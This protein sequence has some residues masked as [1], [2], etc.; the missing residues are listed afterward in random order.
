LLGPGLQ[1]NRELCLPEHL[2]R[3]FCTQASWIVAAGALVSPRSGKAQSLYSAKTRSLLQSDRFQ[4]DSRDEML[5]RH[6][7]FSNWL[8]AFRHCSRTINRVLFDLV[9]LLRLAAKSRSAPVAGE[10]TRLK[11]EKSNK[12]LLITEGKRRRKKTLKSRTPP[13]SNA[14]KVGDAAPETS[15][16]PERPNP[17]TLTEVSKAG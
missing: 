14:P 3:T 8:K 6:V 10:V 5:K 9:E 15:I 4:K 12:R 11:A 7:T 1:A 16:S 2:E 17:E 13:Q